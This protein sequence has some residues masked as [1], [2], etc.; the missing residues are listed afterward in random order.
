MNNLERFKR[1]LAPTT[2][3]PLGLEI[4]KARGSY[5]YDSKNRAYLDFVAGVSAVSIGHSN[6]VIRSAVNR[7]LKKHSH[8]M[9]YGEFI[10][11]PV[12]AYAEYLI[13][14]LHSSLNNVYL[15][16]SGT[17]AIEGALKLA[18]AATGRTE[19]I[20]AKNNYHGNTMG[21][22]SLMDYEE[23]VAPFR[24]LLPDIKHIGFNQLE[25]LNQISEATARLL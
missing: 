10:Q 4:S 7:Q 20:A 24:P 13:A 23:R 14:Q 5:I 21:S 19:I 22:L 15:V 8:V 18:R 9:V 11:E 6:R 17:E 12:V 16:N 2:P 3:H 1:A 25:D